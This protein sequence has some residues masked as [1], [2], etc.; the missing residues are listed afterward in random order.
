VYGDNQYVHYMPL[1]V[2]SK[3][4][5]PDNCGQLLLRFSTNIDLD[6]VIYT[7]EGSEG[8]KETKAMDK[9]IFYAGKPIDIE[10]EVNFSEMNYFFYMRGRVYDPAIKTDEKNE[11]CE[12]ID[13]FFIID[14][15]K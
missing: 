1:K 14:L 15:S 12:N 10:L 9:T 8:V 13:C 6:R 4:L 7:F 2:Y 5:N 11:K 3:N